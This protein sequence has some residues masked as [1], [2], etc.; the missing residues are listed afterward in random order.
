[1]E[2]ELGIYSVFYEITKEENPSIGLFHI[3]TRE[4]YVKELTYIPA[5]NEEEAKKYLTAIFA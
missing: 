5:T 2:G 4:N 1:M 3:Q